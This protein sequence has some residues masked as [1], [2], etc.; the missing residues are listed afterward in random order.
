MRWVAGLGGTLT[1]MAAVL[2]GGCGEAPPRSEP[3]P[4]KVNVAKP[5]PRQIVD[6][7]DYNGWI[8]ASQTVDIRARVRG[9]IVK[10]HFTDGDMVKKD[11]LLFELD[12]RP[13][14]QE[15]D[16]S[17]EQVQIYQAQLNVA[18]VDEKRMRELQKTNSATQVEIDTTY[19][20]AR[21]LEAQVEAQKKEVERKKQELDYSR[22]TSP[23]NGRI[24]RAMMD[25]GNLVN[26]G[27]S[28]PLL[29]TIVA[30]DPM[31]VYFP[32]DERALQHYQK[33]RPSTMPRTGVLRDLKLPFQ[34]GLETDEG[35]PNTGVL[36][37]ADNR[38]DASTG[39]IVVRGA[40]SNP[41]GR[42]VAGSR[43]RVRVPLG[44]QRP[45]LL[46]PD[47]AILAD[48]DRRYVLIVDDKNVAQR[49]DI[50][51]GKLLD[52]GMRI[53]TSGL[54]P[55]DRLVTLG[56]QTARINYPVE[57]VTP[58]TQPAVAAR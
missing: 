24:G 30:M 28:D 4:P 52:D 19:A 43:V 53:V 29:A 44:D 14:Q 27:G 26:A 37:F 18:V 32:I 41:Q 45:V 1:V 20:K 33:L 8:S 35:Y 9:H 25:E 57:P 21:S 7:D 51:M 40:V 50:K 6:A 58:T 38:V 2:A 22:V 3:P 12:P 48:Q 36:D 42:F 39:T 54:N 55:E 23:I 56:L 11:Q 15:V 46:I 34:F 16:R 17:L 31:Q 49:R 10:I 13:F 47:T 5:E